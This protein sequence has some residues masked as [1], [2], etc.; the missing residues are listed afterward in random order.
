MAKLFGPPGKKSLAAAVAKCRAIHKSDLVFIRHRRR[1]RRQR[2]RRPKNSIPENARTTP[3][4]V[5]LTRRAVRESAYASARLTWELCFRRWVLPR[6]AGGSNLIIIIIIGA[7][8]EN[9]LLHLP[10]KK[11]P[12]AS[13]YASLTRSCGTKRSINQPEPTTTAATTTAGFCLVSRGLK[14]VCGSRG[15]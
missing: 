11:G 3:S 4:E 1:W 8:P 15:F 13:Q 9:Q 7:E 14:F 6:E 10:K 2:R 12:N 5:I